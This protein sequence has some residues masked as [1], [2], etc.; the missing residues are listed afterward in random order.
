MDGNPAWK[1]VN[2]STIKEVTATDVSGKLLDTQVS[3]TADLEINVDEIKNLV[4]KGELEVR[5]KGNSREYDLNVSASVDEVLKASG[6][7]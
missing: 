5:L 6:Q 2:H 1:G 3:E 4:G 7:E